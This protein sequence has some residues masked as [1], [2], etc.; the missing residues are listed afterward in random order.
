MLLDMNKL[1]LLA[2]S[3]IFGLMSFGQVAP[4][5]Y[6]IFFTDKNNS[7]YS[8]DNP[9]QFLSSRA[10][11]RRINQ[12]IIL[13]Q[14]DIPV[15]KLYVDSLK[16]LG[17]QVINQSKWMN[18]AIVK[19]TDY[20]LIDTIHTYSF[21]KSTA[22]SG[23]IIDEQKN[24]SGKFDIGFTN[25]AKSLASVKSDYGQATNQIELHNGDILHNLNY[26]GKGIIIAIL[27]AGF[28]KA[29][30]LAAFDSVK[31]E[32][33]ILAT[34]DFV[35]GDTSVYL[36]HDHGMQVFST[37]AANIPGEMIGTAPDASFLLLRT[38]DASS[39]YRIEEFN[40]LCAAEF[41]DSAGADI[42]NTSLGYNL[43]TN[44]SQNY[45]Y[46]DLDGNT[47][48]IARAADIAASKGMLVVVSAG[49]EGNNAWHF[50]T[51]PAD[52][53]SVLTVGA[54][55]YQG[56]YASLSSTGPTIDGRVKPDVVAQGY[57]TTIYLS[58]DYVGNGSGTS[59]AAPII[60]GLSA[61][62]WQAHPQL[63]NMELMNTIKMSSSKFNSPDSLLGYGIPDF[64]FAN[65][66]LN[67]INYNNFD[68]ESLTRLYPN[69]F[70]NYLHIDFYSVD[71]QDVILEIIDFTGKVVC[72]KKYTVPLTSYNNITIRDLGSLR[73]GIYVVR[74]STNQ[75]NWQRK[76]IK[77]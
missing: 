77:G 12:G 47:S 21:V 48:V 33:R 61:C 65:L 9:E 40:W 42:I 23:S 70:N 62:L 8:V 10:I 73:S 51:T 2:F 43:F 29:N 5:K 55:N 4:D 53:D 39:E 14:N 71:S 69:P 17:L 52:A 18:C 27:D 44:S 13:S 28:M 59:F 19:T 72:S 49:N 45:T 30:T 22:K 35:D 25:A 31:S 15:N 64:A 36:H 38:E 46:N 37:I 50:I 74:I 11:S 24:T 6:V 75:N 68:A 67:G 41:A 54:V 63:S 26:R 7:E 16:S 1:F 20:L 34:K 3:V 56:E 76:I 57:G 32:S 60:A 58:G 66:L